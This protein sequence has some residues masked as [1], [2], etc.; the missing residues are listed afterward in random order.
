M[1]VISSNLANIS[2]TRTAEGGPYKKKTVTIAAEDVE[3]PFFNDIMERALKSVKVDSITEDQNA[4]KYIYEP[5]HPDADPDGYVAMPDINLMM[6]MAHM[7]G[8]SRAY[9]AGVTALDA[10]KDITM[11]ALDIGR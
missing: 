2:T 11:K 5:G 1:D 10:T 9:Q 6:E 3:P 7:L 8:A 4:V